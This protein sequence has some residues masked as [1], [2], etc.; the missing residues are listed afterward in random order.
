MRELLDELNNPPV[1]VY[2][3]WDA[4]SN[5]SRSFRLCDASINGFGGTLERERPDGSIRPI[6]YI[7]R[8][9]LI[10]ERHWTPLNLEAGSIIWFIKRL[11]G[12]LWG[13]HF[14]TY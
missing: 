12:Y 11:R 7:S 2:P 10:S 3:D 8:A 13:L 9:T 14:H 1:L 5:A 6:V 4:A